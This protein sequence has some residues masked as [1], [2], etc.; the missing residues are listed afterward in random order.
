[1]LDFMSHDIFLL[2]KSPKFPHASLAQ[3]SPNGLLAVG[4]DLSD[5]RLI[6]AYKNGI[7]PWYCEGEPILW[8]S[9]DPRC[10]FLLDN[11]HTSRSLRRVK[12]ISLPSHHQPSF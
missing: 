1:M 7:F 5:E 6:E 4:G 8:W 10:V 3:D 9:P 12:K 2:D 11:V